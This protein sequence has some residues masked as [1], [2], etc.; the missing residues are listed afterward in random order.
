MATIKDVARLA[1]VGVGT[2]SRTLSGNGFVSP[3][4]QAKVHAA[5]AELDFRPSHIGRALSAN[6]L[7]M[8][9]IFVS[10]FRSK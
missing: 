9:G 8:I 4:A 10:F 1:G 7:G 2:A 5:I 3:A 6:S